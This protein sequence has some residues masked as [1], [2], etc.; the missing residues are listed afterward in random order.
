MFVINYEFPYGE[1]P[2]NRLCLYDRPIQST[3]SR[4]LIAKVMLR[5]NNIFVAAAII[6]ATNDNVKGAAEKLL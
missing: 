1:K 5:K 2:G 3:I 6:N 4:A